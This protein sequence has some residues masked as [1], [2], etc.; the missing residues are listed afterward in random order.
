MV[1]YK[2]VYGCFGNFGGRVE[3]VNVDEVTTDYGAIL[4]M[5]ID[6]MVERGDFGSLYTIDEAEANGWHEDEY[7][8]GGNECYALYHGGNF[9]IL[10]DE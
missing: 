1:T 9:L 3:L 7:V 6:Q 5:A 10:Q 2:V 4:D 8:I